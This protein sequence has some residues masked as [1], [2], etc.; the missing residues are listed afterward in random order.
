MFQWALCWSCCQILYTAL[1]T[2]VCCCFCYPSQHLLFLGLLL[3]M[4]LSLFS[5]V[6]PTGY[7]EV[8][9]FKVLRSPPKLGCQLWD[10]CF[11]NYHGYVP[12]V[13]ITGFENQINTTGATSGAG[14]AYP[15]GTDGSLAVFSVVRVNRSLVLCVCLV[16][17]RLSFLVL[18][19]VF[20]S[21]DFSLPPLYHQTLFTI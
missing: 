16:D 2:F 20:L 7:V 1:S 3:L 12:F 8:I 18:T 15:S 13:V 5:S 17:N 4:F 21:F 11:T 10:I 6:V 9:I 14:A 19:I